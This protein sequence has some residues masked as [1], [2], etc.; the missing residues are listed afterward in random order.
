MA[1]GVSRNLE[2]GPINTSE[3]QKNRVI[4]LTK[5]NSSSPY[6]Y[7]NSMHGRQPE[8]NAACVDNLASH[9]W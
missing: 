4:T 7:D 2:N 6:T 3:N 8:E 1:Y 5:R 9:M